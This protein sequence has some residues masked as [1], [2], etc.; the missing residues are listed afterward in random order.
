MNKLIECQKTIASLGMQLKS[1]ATLNDFLV[2]NVDLPGLENEGLGSRNENEVSKGSLDHG[3][4][5]K[6][7]EICL[8]RYGYVEGSQRIMDSSGKAAS[9]RRNIGI[10][11]IFV[12]SKNTKGFA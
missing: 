4:V 3:R 8:R 9:K 5:A 7:K 11:S 6:D 1:L 12:R 10:G 2:E